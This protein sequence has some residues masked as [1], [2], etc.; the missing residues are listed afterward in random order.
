MAS[1]AHWGYDGTPG[2]HSEEAQISRSN[3]PDQRRRCGESGRLQRRRCLPYQVTPSGDGVK[4]RLRSW[5]P[6][7]EAF[8]GR[9]R[10]ADN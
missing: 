2:Q 1:C 8:D 9:Q 3:G 7:L 5:I 10:Y 6:E 4:F